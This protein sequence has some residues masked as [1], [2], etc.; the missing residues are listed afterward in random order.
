MVY[1]PIGHVWDWKPKGP[2]RRFTGG[3]VAMV[4]LGNASPAFCAF[5]HEDREMLFGGNLG[6]PIELPAD[7]LEVIEEGTCK[8]GDTWWPGCCAPKEEPAIY[9]CG[10]SKH[11]VAAGLC[12]LYPKEAK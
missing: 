7:T 5:V 8:H 11:K 9:P 3:E 1:G 6:G 10:C 2:A 4:V 12:D